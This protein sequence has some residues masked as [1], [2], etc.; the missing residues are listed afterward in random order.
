MWRCKIIVGKLQPIGK[1][2]C[3]QVLQF[4]DAGKGFDPEIKKVSNIGKVTDR[5]IVRKKLTD[6]RRVIIGFIRGAVINIQPGAEVEVFIQE[7]LECQPLAGV[8]KGNTHRWIG[9]GLLYYKIAV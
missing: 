3:I 8:E 7:S 1:V 4:Y 5:W 2:Q 6:N 9:A